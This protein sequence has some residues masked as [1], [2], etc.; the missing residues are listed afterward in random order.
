M[1]AVGE[2]RVGMLGWR[3]VQKSQTRM[4]CK[5]ECCEKRNS[6]LGNEKESAL[7]EVLSATKLQK[8]PSKIDKY[9]SFKECYIGC[10]N[11]Y[12]NEYKK[13]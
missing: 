7:L 2:R 12:A 8:H 11:C 13:K 9:S 10:N 6:S 1:E 3:C 5:V 4:R